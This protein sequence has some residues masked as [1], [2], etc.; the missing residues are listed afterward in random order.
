MRK[1]LRRAR[2]HQ[3]TLFAAFGALTTACSQNSQS[4]PKSISAGSSGVVRGK[5]TEEDYGV[6]TSDRVA[7]PGGS[8]AK[9]G[10]TFKLG[11]PYSVAGRWYVPREEPGYNREGR[12]SWYGDDF[13]GRK[14]ANGEVFDKR[15]LSAAHPT[16]P[17]PSYAYVTNIDNGRTILVRVNDRGPYANDRI[18]DMSHAAARAW[19]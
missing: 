7:G 14:T 13:H 11:S 12:A 3:V 16:L 10:G 5:F 9:G 8:V 18:L 15:A 17:L 1:G 4:P 2:A 6:R 19:L